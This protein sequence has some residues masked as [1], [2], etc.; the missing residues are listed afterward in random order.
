[1]EVATCTCCDGDLYLLRGG[2]AM[3]PWGS[4][5]WGAAQNWHEVAGDAAPA[6][7]QV[8]LYL[9]GYQRWT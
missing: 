7:A 2:W 5:R 6:G 8:A 3:T 9:C 1:M 4:A